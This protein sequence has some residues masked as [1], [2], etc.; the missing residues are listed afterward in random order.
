MA[1]TEEGIIKSLQHCW[2]Q[3]KPTRK[4]KGKSL[5][6]PIHVMCALV[7]LYGHLGGKPVMNK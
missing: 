3:D 5:S 6:L 2:L 7:K 1:N 4:A